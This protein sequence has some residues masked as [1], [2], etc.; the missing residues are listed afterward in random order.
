MEGF[1]SSSLEQDIGLR[2]LFEK[3]SEQ[4]SKNTLVE[5]VVKSE[6]LGGDLDWGFAYIKESSYFPNEEEV[7]FNPINIF[8]VHRCQ[9][10]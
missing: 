9:E 7:L 8:R 1:L 6:N 3:K 4:K 5:I 2:Y 10:E